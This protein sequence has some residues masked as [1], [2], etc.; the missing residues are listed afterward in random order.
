M[1]S[2]TSDNDGLVSDGERMI[3]GHRGLSSLAPENT[4]AAFRCAVDHQVGWVEADVDIIADGTVIICHDSTLD[5]TTNRAGRYDDLTVADLAGI[6]AGGWFS[7]RFKGESLPT[8]RNLIDLMNATGLNANIEI[9]PNGTG[10]EATLRLIDGVIA[11]LEHLRPGAE[12]IVSSFSHLLLHL[13]KQRAPHVPVGCLYRSRTLSDDWRSTLQ[14]VGADYIH[15]EDSGLTRQ[16][17]QTFRSEGYGVN[18]WTVNSLGR[19]NELFNWGATGIFS[20]I[21]HQIPRR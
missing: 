20:D 16:Q 7:P 5:R 21:A 15:P 1:S 18:V 11:Q 17:V 3:I 4:M 14:I 6:D 2:A 19:A 13:F 9:K 10:R 8:L 12:V